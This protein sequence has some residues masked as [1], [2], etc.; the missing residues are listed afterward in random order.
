ME[1]VI[2]AVETNFCLLQ[3]VLFY[4]EFFLLVE[5]KE[6]KQFLK[7]KYIPSSQHQFFDI[8]RDFKIFL[9]W[10]QLLHKVET[11]LLTNPSSG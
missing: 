8:F 5:I 11:H 2:P 6:I 7:T 3:T 1:T 10:K 4:S 9:K